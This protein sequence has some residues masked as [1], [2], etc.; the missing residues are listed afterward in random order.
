MS[1]IRLSVL[2]AC[3]ALVAL[4]PANANFRICN[5]SPNRMSIALAYIDG[6]GWV[7]EGWWNLKSGACDTILRG[8]LAAEFYYVYAMDEHGG[9]WKGKT[10][11][12]TLTHQFRIT[13]RDNCY[14]RGYDRTQFIEVDTG[15][16]AKDWTVDLTD[17]NAPLVAEPTPATVN[18]STRTPPTN[19]VK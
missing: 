18:P 12:C 16:N 10:P 7:S 5:K 19:P 6:S 8:Q 15:Q 14:S 3:A 13:G 4:S 17:P 2:S 9:E 1:F 11:M